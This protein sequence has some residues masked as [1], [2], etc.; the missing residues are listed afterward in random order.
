VNDSTALSVIDKISDPQSFIIGMG[1]M[2]ALSTMFG[3]KTEAQGVVLAMHCVMTKQSPL[4][5]MQRYHFIEGKL[6]MKSEAMLAEF[7]R[8]GG[9]YEWEADGRDGKRAALKM[10]LDG[11]TYVSEYTIDE[12][13]KAGLVKPDKPQSG[14][15]ASRPNMLRARASSN[16]VRMLLPEAVVGMYTPEEMEDAGI[17]TID[18]ADVTVKAAESTQVDLAAAAATSVETQQKRGRGRPAKQPAEATEAVAVDTSAGSSATVTPAVA[19]AASESAPVVTEAPAASVTAAAPAAVAVA[20]SAD[21]IINEILIT[22]SAISAIV[23]EEK[24]AE[25][26]GKAFAA[27]KIPTGPTDEAR[28][29]L[30]E[31]AARKKVRDW[32]S[33]QLKA[34]EA[35]VAKNDINTW[36]NSPPATP[37][38]P[39][40]AT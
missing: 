6:S 30:I 10:T 31:E 23:G 29:M 24:F 3:C 27:L 33:G 20:S 7:R 1:R 28:L 22:K 37:K 39:A 4:V 34:A 16:G 2:F 13:M 18:P 25:V 32:L 8:A 14:W 11:V 15:M 17:I 26:W 9:R 38:H 40:A 36:A 35:K 21:P 19:V 12:A 5:I